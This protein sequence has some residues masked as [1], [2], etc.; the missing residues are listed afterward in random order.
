MTRALRLGLFAVLLAPAALPAAPLGA[1]GGSLRSMQRQNAVARQE[2]FA[3]VRTQAQLRAL[4]DDGALV[5]VDNSA[6]VQLL[7]YVHPYAQP[8]VRLLVERLGAQYRATTGQPLV[9]TSLVRPTAEQP[10]NSHTLSVHPAGMALDLR[11]PADAK[12]RRWLERTLLALEAEGVLDVTREFRPPHYHVAVFPA[13]YRAHVARQG[14]AAPAPVA[15]ASVPV[16]APVTPAVLALEPAVAPTAVPTVAPA[17]PTSLPGPLPLPLAAT[18][19]A[20][21]A[22]GMVAIV[23]WRSAH[24]APQAG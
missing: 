19:A 15:A 12:A 3:F 9:V 10:S 7:S 6:D 1:L 16:A 24:R 22:A 11:V 8:E 5:R 18:V 20:G 17:L 23:R 2:E 21:A 13:A 4:V 14:G